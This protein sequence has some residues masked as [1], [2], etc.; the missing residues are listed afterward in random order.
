MVNVSTAIVQGVKIFDTIDMTKIIQ[1]ITQN[2]QILRWSH[3]G[4]SWFLQKM[5]LKFH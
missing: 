2:E 1:N 5:A 4:F 3:T